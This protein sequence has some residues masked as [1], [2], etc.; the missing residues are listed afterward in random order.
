LCRC[1]ELALRPIHG[2]TPL[3]SCD[4]IDTLTYNESETTVDVQVLSVE[5]ALISTFLD[6]IIHRDHNNNPVGH[7]WTVITKEESDEHQVC[8][9]FILVSWGCRGITIK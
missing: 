4:V 3:W 2:Q 7:N 6:F 1:L 8:Q 9:L 5:K